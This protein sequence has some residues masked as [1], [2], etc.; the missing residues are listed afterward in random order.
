MS[1]K[2]LY[3]IIMTIY[4]EGDDYVSTTMYGDDISK[5]KS[6]VQE[7]ILNT[8]RLYLVPIGKA[9]AEMTIEDNKGEYI[10]HDETEIFI[11]EDYES[12]EYGGINMIINRVAKFERISYE[13]WCKDVTMKIAPTEKDY[14]NIV[15]PIRKTKGSAGYD[16]IA[17][18]NI[19][20]HPNAE[21]LIPTGVK[22][23]IEEGYVLEL[24]PRSSLGFKYNLTLANTVGIIDSD[25][26]NN[27]NNEGHIMIKMINNSHNVIHIN[28]GESFAQGVFKQFFITVDD[29]VINKRVGGIGS[30]NSK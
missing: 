28:Q 1:D 12:I 22:C 14:D 3:R 21:I 25:Y 15:T 5:L 10:D 24:Y 13:Q 19:A 7:D 4:F 16:F 20:I 2:K 30:T 9:Y 8:C 26:Y 29:N 18:Y 11:T 6:D 27:E 23:E 17:P